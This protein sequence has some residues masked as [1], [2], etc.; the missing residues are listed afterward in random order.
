VEQA[1][2]P[3][4]ELRLRAV[5]AQVGLRFGAKLGEELRERSERVAGIGLLAVALILLG[6]KLLKL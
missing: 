4:D 2:Q 3:A 5:A 1:L 6:L